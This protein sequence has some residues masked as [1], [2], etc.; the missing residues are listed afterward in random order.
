MFQESSGP[1]SESQKSS[2]PLKETSSSPESPSFSPI[3]NPAPSW[4]SL[5]PTY[6]P[7]SPIYSANDDCPHNPFDFTAIAF[8]QMTNRYNHRTASRRASRRVRRRIAMEEST[9]VDPALI[10]SDHIEM[11][12]IKIF[13][14]KK[15]P[16]F[17]YN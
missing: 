5:S 7:G 8:H 12:S 2:T 13:I 4:T 11:V 16:K 9:S 17:P 14:F 6:C 3:S 1:S 15:I 10:L